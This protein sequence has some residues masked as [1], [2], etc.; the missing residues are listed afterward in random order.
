MRITYFNRSPVAGLDFPAEPLPTIEAVLANADV[1]S[2]HI[3]GGGDNR[4]VISASLIAAM[5]PSAYLVNTA[6]GD[7]VDETALAEA[8]AAGRLAGAGLDVYADEP[9]VPDALLRLPSVTLLPHIG[10]ATVETRTAMGM[11]AVD[12]LEAFFAGREMPSRVA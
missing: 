4:G 5:K 9:T 12:N 11:L 6:R 8:L 2:L 10:S 7:V 1:V 3:P